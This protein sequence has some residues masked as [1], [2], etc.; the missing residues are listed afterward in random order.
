MSSCGSGEEE[1][2]EYKVVHDGLGTSYFLPKRRCMK[3]DD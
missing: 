1:E 3:C 2:T